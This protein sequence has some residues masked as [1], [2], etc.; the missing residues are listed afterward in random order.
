MTVKYLAILNQSGAARLANA[1]A[2]GTKLNITQMAVG[3]ANGV[4]PTP[5][6]AQTK[7]INQKRIASINT[8]SADPNNASQIIAEQIIPEE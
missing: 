8:L 2:L 7:L 6:L 1:V 4:L 5:D 3:D